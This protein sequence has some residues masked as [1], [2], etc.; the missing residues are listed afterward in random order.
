MR[1][2]TVHA[3]LTRVISEVSRSLSFFL[4]G[5]QC[6]ASSIIR[7]TVLKAFSVRKRQA[8]SVLHA[9]GRIAF[10]TVILMVL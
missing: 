2:L 3:R 9:A 8:D 10:S 7:I 6:A 5:E 4:T 1:V